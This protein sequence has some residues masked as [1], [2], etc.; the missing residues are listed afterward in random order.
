MLGRGQE[1][2]NAQGFSYFVVGRGFNE[3]GLRPRLLAQECHRLAKTISSSSRFAMRWWARAKTAVVT[4]YLGHFL[5]LA[6]RRV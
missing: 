5:S 2:V 3:P 6:H 4:N 1:Q